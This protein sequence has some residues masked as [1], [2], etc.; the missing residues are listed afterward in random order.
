MPPLLPPITLNMKTFG[1]TATSF[2]RG[3]FLKRRREDVDSDSESD[4]SDSGS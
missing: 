3:P 1:G 4:G 2:D